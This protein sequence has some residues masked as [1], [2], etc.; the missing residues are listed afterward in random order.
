MKPSGILFKL[1]HMKM[2]LLVRK[3]LSFE[4]Y[5]VTAVRSYHKDQSLLYNTDEA[6]VQIVNTRGYW[7]ADP[8]L[9]VLNGKTWLFMEAFDRRKL[10]GRIACVNLSEPDRKPEIVLWE[11]FH[12]SFPQVFSWN[13]DIW[14]IPETGDDCSLRLYRA[15]HFPN[16]WQ[17]VARFPT[18]TSW[19]DTVVVDS[20]PEGL[21]LLTSEVSQERQ[22]FYRFHR[23]MLRGSLSGG[24]VLEDDK[25]F[26]EK[27]QYSHYSR[28][29]GG[30]FQ[31]KGGRI[32]P[33]QES[34]P[35]Q[36]G[37]KLCFNRYYGT[38]D[39][40]AHP[41]GK[42]ISA[43]DVKIRDMTGNRICRK[44]YGVHS[45]ARDEQYEVIDINYLIFS[46][47]KYLKRFIRNHA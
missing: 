18:Q 42:T 10:L 15:E 13:D 30:V 34:T 44:P 39:V 23:V 47:L 21:T 16:K 11:D 20:A 17:L 24:F 3:L 28:N 26:L 45:Y 4:D 40:L 43:K 35:V 5:Y 38:E 14:M 32:L 2:D 37:V 19:V 29:A 22:Y 27:Q 36:Y 46:P 9:Y 7:Y 33:T 8:A 1:T 6:F 31:E 41:V 25:S 12:L